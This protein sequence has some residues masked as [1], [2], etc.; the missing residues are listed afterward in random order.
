[1]ALQFDYIDDL[2]GK[3]L[4]GEATEAESAEVKAWCAQTE[5]NQKYFDDLKA[6]FEKAASTPVQVQ[7][8]TDAAWQQLRAKLKDEKVVPLRRETNYW[9]ALRMAA[10]VV[11]LISAGIFTYRWFTQPVQTIAV[12][13]DTTT[14]ENTLPDSSTVFLNRHSQ[15]TYEY[16]PRQ[17][18]RRVKLQ[19]EGFFEIKHE[20]EKP[21]V[22]ETEDVF[23]RDIGTAF[24]VKS[25]PDK[26]TVEVIVQSGEVQ[27]YTLKNPGLYLKAGETGIYTK[28]GK[29]FTKIPRADTNALAYKTRIFSFYATDLRS[30]VDRVNE[31]YGSNIKLANEQ[32]GECRLTTTFSNESLD[33]IV[34]IIAEAMSLTV[35]RKGEEII[36]NGPGCQ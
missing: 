27:F 13:S 35:E 15:V 18:T 12:V 26:D 24:N 3:H 14:L 33:V 28:R 21:F 22:I 20:E 8:N 11:L 1:M 7:F 5:A 25:Y 31:V 19:G 23:V 17:K 34:E 30:V 32:V 9:P 6:I 2:I 29:V 36:L 16:N 10:G 4:A